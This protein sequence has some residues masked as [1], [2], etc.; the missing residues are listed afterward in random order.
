VR[1]WPGKPYPLGATWDGKGVNLSLF[2][3]HATG[4]ELCLFD[5]VDA[6]QETARVPLTEQTDRVWHGYLPEIRPGQLCGYRVDGPYDPRAGHRFNPAKVVLDP[7]TKQV[8]RRCLA[9]LARSGASLV[10][11]NLE[12]LWLEASPQNV[13]GTSWER[14][15]WRRRSRHSLEALTSMPQ[16]SDI[17][18]LVVH[19]RETRRRRKPRRR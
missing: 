2:S 13:P 16:V 18:H 14:S 12:D 7:H 15:N 3:E 19:G 17:L 1:V 11:V 6:T 5:S 9:Q 8:G 10:I 4:V